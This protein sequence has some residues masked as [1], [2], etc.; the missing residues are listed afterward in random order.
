[1][2]KKMTDRLTHKKEKDDQLR[3]LN[4]LFDSLIFKMMKLENAVIKTTNIPLGVSVFT[5]AKK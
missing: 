2:L 5:V 4:P 1:M 3:T